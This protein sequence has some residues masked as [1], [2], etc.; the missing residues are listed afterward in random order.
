MDWKI[1]K[2]GVVREEYPAIL[3]ADGAGIVEQVGEGVTA[4]KK[5][6]KVLVRFASSRCETPAHLFTKPPSRR[7]DE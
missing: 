5:G 6:D 4:F 3:G 2:Y 7:V 1:P